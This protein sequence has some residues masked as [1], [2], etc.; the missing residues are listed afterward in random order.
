MEQRQNDFSKGSIPRNIMGLALLRKA[1][2][3]APLTLILLIWLGTIGVFAAEAV[4]QLIGGLA[5]F[6]TMYF[7]VCRPLKRRTDGGM[8][9]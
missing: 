6:T 7:T 3:N 4:S 1:I 8:G 9:I 2:I 5:S